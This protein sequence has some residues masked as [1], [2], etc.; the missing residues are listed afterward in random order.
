MKW[1]TIR[2]VLLLSFLVPLIS[3]VGC[4]RYPA[5][6]DRDNVK[7]IAALRTACSAQDTEWL[8]KAVENI[9]ARFDEGGM[10]DSS[11]KTF[12]AIIEQARAGEWRDAEMKAFKFL[13]SQS[14]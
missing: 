3:A 9:D 14:R 11:Y 8:E 7:L 5:V 4:T 6:E 13:E 1:N 2:L 10:S 12:Q